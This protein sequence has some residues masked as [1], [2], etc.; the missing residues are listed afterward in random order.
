M[1]Y[2]RVFMIDQRNIR[3]IFI[4]MMVMMVVYTNRWLKLIFHRSR[5][6]LENINTESEIHAGSITN[7]P[8]AKSVQVILVYLNIK[9]LN[10]YVNL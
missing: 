2:V 3:E 1:K 10:F 4:P 9:L 8:L 7:R 6:N 5:I